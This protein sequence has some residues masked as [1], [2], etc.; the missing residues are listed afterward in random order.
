MRKETTIKKFD[1]ES[2]KSNKSELARQY[3][4][5]WRTIDRRLSP[6]KYHKEKTKR[7]Y[8]SM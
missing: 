1:L 5:C 4:R 2:E 7:I 8:K 3:G 6:E